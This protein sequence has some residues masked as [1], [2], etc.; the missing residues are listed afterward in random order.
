MKTINYNGNALEYKSTHKALYEYELMAGKDDVT[1][2]TDSL[3]LMYCI[4][5]T[6]AKK[7]GVK[8]E[9]EFEQFIDWLDDNPEALKGI[10]IEKE[11]TSK[12]DQA[13][14]K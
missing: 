9:L 3:R 13:K 5:K 11:T 8:F 12:D 4:V 1:T 10:T 14:K 7:A 2:Y 6:Q